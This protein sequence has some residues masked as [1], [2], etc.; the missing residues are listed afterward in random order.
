MS[1]ERDWPVIGLYAAGF[2]GGAAL[3]ITGSY[4]AFVRPGEIRERTQPVFDEIGRVVASE[5]PIS[6]SKAETLSQRVLKTGELK[7]DPRMESV[8]YDLHIA[9]HLA[10]WYQEPKQQK[11]IREILQKSS[12]DMGNIR[13]DLIYQAWWPGAVFDAV[14]LMLLGIAS[15]HALKKRARAWRKKRTGR[16][17]DIPSNMDTKKI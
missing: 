14:G 4:C 9:Q 11:L 10:T 13:H 2:G 5:E 3:I 17:I 7:G 15:Y 6:A 1:K 8:N 16:V 12:Q